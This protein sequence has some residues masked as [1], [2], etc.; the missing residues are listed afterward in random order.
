MGAVAQ[1]L[2]RAKRANV[3][4]DPRFIAGVALIVVSVL[5]TTWLLHK[6]RGGEE[7]YQLTSPVAQ[8]QPI[9]MSHVSIVSARVGSNAYIPV[10]EI[11]EGAVAT[12]SLSAGE[13][14]PRDAVSTEASQDRRQ[15]VVNVSTRIPS[16]V[17]VGSEVD[18]WGI[19]SQGALEANKTEP[20]VIATA[21]IILAISEPDN[22]MLDRAQS[23]ELSVTKED[24][25][26]VLA[27]TGSNGALIIVPAG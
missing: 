11:P 27:A 1:D 25:A 9:S 26:K 8:G 13:L 15:V 5:L 23:I 16:S 22:T 18:L 12:R 21:A 7:L 14:L 19:A 6:A 10:G 24:L 20:E 4:R 17:D 2:P 3:L